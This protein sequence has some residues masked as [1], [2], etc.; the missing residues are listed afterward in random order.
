MFLTLFK[1]LTGGFL[2]TL[3]KSY[4][5]KVQADTDRFK[6]GSETDRVVVLKQ[7]DVEIEARKAAAAARAADRGHWST[8]WMLP[9]LFA[10]CLI[11]FAAVTFDSLPLF[12]HIVGSWR[13]PP[14][15]GAFGENQ[16]TI[17]LSVTGAVTATRVARIFSR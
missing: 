8:A 12:G 9:S 10:V 4:M 13:I 7:L 2:D 17:L 11:H 5:A 16:H 3:A 14:L 1:F 15:P 6:I